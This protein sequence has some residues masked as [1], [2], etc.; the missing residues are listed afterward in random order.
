MS[1]IWTPGGERPLRSEPDPPSSPPSSA[2]PG[3]GGRPGAPGD[4]LTAEERAEL[5]QELATMQEQV[6]STP[7]AVVVA[8]HAVGLFQLAAIHLNRQPPNLPEGRIAIDAM[9]ALV[10]GMAGRLGDEEQALR[11]GLGQ[12]QMAFVQLSG[13][14]GAGGDAGDGDRGGPQA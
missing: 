10:E 3:G 14:S 5:E 1:S 13:G 7:A 4:D 11:D 2:P 12:L 8:N 6:A 9:A